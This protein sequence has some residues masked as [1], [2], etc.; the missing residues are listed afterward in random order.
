MMNM[1]G[2]EEKEEQTIQKNKA[3]STKAREAYFLDFA[4]AMKEVVKVPLMV[5]GG[6]RTKAAMEYAL[7]SGG[8]DLI[9]IGRPLCVL[10]DAPKRLLD[11][12][13]DV[14]PRYEDNL[15]LIPKWLSALKRF[16]M[17]KL[18]NSFASIFW[19][20]EQLDSLGRTGQ[21]N[22]KVGTFAALTATDK[23]SKKILA[24]RTMGVT[25]KKAKQRST[26]GKII[27]VALVGAAVAAGLAHSK[28]I[29]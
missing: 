20:Y 6:F 16:Q 25:V 15:D 9:G 2:I 11:G 5:T 22:A 3:P 4:A 26:T 27:A 23:R 7:S 19:F 13:L 1:P 12:S 14:L 18:V 17:M 28:R 29:K 24:G 21:S 10:T 8:A